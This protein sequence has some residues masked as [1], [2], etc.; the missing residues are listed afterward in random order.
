MKCWGK[1]ESFVGEGRV[2]KALSFDWAGKQESCSLLRLGREEKSCSEGC[3]AKEEA[4][5]T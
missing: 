3:A 5:P 4:V 2:E 1:Q